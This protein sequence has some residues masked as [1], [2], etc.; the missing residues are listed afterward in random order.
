MKIK[1]LKLRE[2]WVSM[3]LEDLDEHNNLNI[4]KNELRYFLK[5]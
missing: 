3:A 2:E 5:R 4:L 1:L